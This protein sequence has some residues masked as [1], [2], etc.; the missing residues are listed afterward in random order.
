VHVHHQVTALNLTMAGTAFFCHVILL[1]V[2]YS[3]EHLEI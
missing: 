3:N 1:H 2:K